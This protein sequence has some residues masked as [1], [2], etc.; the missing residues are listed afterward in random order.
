MQRRNQQ[1]RVNLAELKTQIV[2]KIGVERT[3]LYLYYLNKFLNLKLSKVEFNKLCFR[4]LG[5]ENIPLHNE[6]ICSI[7]KNACNAKISPPLNRD[8]EVATSASDG[9]HTFPNG[10]ADFASHLSTITSDNRASEDGIP[11]PVQHHQVLSQKG[12]TEGD[13]LFHHP[14]KLLLAK[15]STDGSLS[16]Q[17]K[18]QSKIFVDE[19]RKE[20]SAVSSLEAP[21]GIPF[22]SVSVGG[23]RKPLPLASNDRCTSSY[24]N[25]GLLDTQSLRERMQQIAVAQGLDEVSMDS[26]NLL[27]FGLDAYLKGLIKSCIELVGTR[28]GCDLVT[29]NSQKQNSRMKLVNGFW[30]GHSMQVQSSGRVLDGVQEQRYHFSISLMDFKVAMELNPQQ[31]GE[32]CPLLLE[33]I[34]HVIEE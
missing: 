13:V 11:K 14:N 23:A 8:K 30:P 12:D 9:S 2:K 32:D 28:H 26:A 31:L 4:I 7:L 3:K 10:K 15:R 21:L 5:R 29:K 34:M 33:K 25:G 6:F 1:S 22:C 16:I 27:N 24:D 19:D 17:C 18:E 20:I